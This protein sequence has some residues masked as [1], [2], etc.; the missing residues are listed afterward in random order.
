MLV[1]TSVYVDVLRDAEFAR[2]F[3]PRYERDIPRTYFS[4]VV[5][6]E[7][8]AGVRTLTHRRLAVALFEPFERARRIAVPTHAVWKEAGSVLSRLY[9]DA[10]ECR[11]K[12]R[13]GLLNDVLIALT[14]RSIGAA[15][16]TRNGD[17]FE[18]IRR[19]RRFALE[20]I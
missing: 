18:L 9:A 6:Q 15:L 16:V 17:D 1:D 8:L 12:L 11:D 2:E 14:A 13:R 19:T 7:L 5:A 4:S 10:P 20:V 3:R